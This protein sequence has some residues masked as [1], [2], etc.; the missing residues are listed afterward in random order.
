VKKIIS[1]G[2][3]SGKTYRLTQEM[4][5][6]L[7]TGTRASGIIATTFTSKAAA[8]LQERVRTKLLEE[9]L[10]EQ[11]NDL[12]NALIGTVHG[13][14]VKLLKRFAFEAG[15]SPQVDI[16]ADEDS[17]IFFNQSLSQILT[18]ERVETMNNLCDKLGLTKKGT[19]DWRKDVHQL[20]DV[21]RANAF[22]KEVLEQS[23]IR[24]FETFKAFLGDPLSSPINYY[25]KLTEL[26]TQT[27]DTLDAGADETKVTGDG[28]GELKI[29]RNELRQR[30]SLHWHQWVKITKL[31]VGAKSKEAVQ[32]LVDFAKM[33]T[34]FPDFQD[35]IRDFIYKMF[36]IAMQAI[37][38]YDKFKKQRGLIDYTD[39]EVLVRLLLNDPSV[40]AVLKE[41]LDLLMVD[42][43]QDTSPIQLDIFLKLSKIA[44][45]SIWVGDPKQSIYGFRGA[46]P[47]LMHAIIAH[48]GIKSEDILKDSWRSRPDI[49]NATNAIFCKAFA[50]LPAEQVALRPKRKDGAEQKDALMHWHFIFD[51]GGDARKRQP[52]S[53][54]SENCIA[55]SLKVFL[56]RGALILPKDEKTYRPALAG[57]IAILC[58]TNDQCKNMAEA[59]HRIGLKAAI[60]RTGLLETAEAKL[61]L[62]VLR[63][64]LN[65][66]DSLS[67]AEILLLA[68]KKEL[69]EIIEHRLQYLDDLVEGVYNEKWAIDND[70]IRKIS[71]LRKETTELSS[72]E[73][74][75]LV[76]EE[77]DLRRIIAAWGNATQRLENVDV[78]RKFSLK[79]ESA[80]NRLHKAAS[81]GG[82]LLWLG[83]LQDRDQDTQ[84]SGEN[85]DAVNILTY[86][87]SKGL[88][89]PVVIMG[90]LENNIRDQVFGMSI[91]PDVAGEE[92]KTVNLDDIL[93]GRWLRFWVNPYGDLYKNTE[94]AEHI[95]S[96]D[97]KA[98]ATLAAL[99]EEARLLYVGITRA[100]DYLIF[101]TS[102][103]PTK[104]LNRSWHNGKEDFPTLESGNDTPFQWEEKYLMK[105]YEEF[106]YEKDFG[107]ADAQIERISFIQER[108]GKNSY[109]PY[110]MDVEKE[111]NFAEHR[112]HQ[113]GYGTSMKL[114]EDAQPFLVAK[115]FNT[116]LTAASPDAS[117]MALA[118][119]IVERYAITDMVD[120]QQLIKTGDAFLAHLN[121]KFAV[122]NI[123]YRYPIRTH[124]NH[125]LFE[126]VIDVFIETTDDKICIIKNIDFSSTDTRKIL[127]EAGQY[128][129]E[130]NWM[131]KSVLHL[132]PWVKVETYLHFM[133]Y[134]VLVK[135]DV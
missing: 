4:V 57:D 86:H 47:R 34:Q 88:E 30:E 50:E 128:A 133:M 51:N 75:N 120:Y 107:Y 135:M 134:S 46:E 63:Y 33:H 16:I 21:A 12:S 113:A 66:H 48:I 20:T 125:R 32:E 11:A 67:V 5:T 49:V 126:T 109:A 13:L 70:F 14:G 42:E 38:E 81:L 9:G 118:K 85:K 105:E 28:K 52:G 31:K 40:L 101:P 73:I 7:R 44:K 72:N 10:T 15:V 36:D 53:P 6:L 131:K 116:Y 93:G 41:E 45:D 123:Q 80:C 60:A 26:L 132:H 58:R 43:F 90:S 17:Q 87:R 89:Y 99:A 37:A 78:I 111:H 59:L 104:W 19:Y 62:A 79:Y 1:A 119:N 23:K 55:E 84:S 65:K 27:I 2:A 94:L 18:Y 117:R 124:F 108:F 39:M 82:F 29:I 83:N 127:T 35:N 64:I 110:K 112:V 129:K 106:Y 98:K 121:K 69:A 25:E 56:E 77:L 103:T 24:S 61:I 115:A 68:E 102:Q 54:W 3:G 122:K 92:G 74:L 71:D 76:L 95:D 91:E 130:L 96:S 22:S 97:A 114:K 8:E 100:R